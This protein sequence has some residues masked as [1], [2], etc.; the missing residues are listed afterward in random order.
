MEVR[1]AHEILS[2]TLEMNASKLPKET[3][4]NEVVQIDL[5]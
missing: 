3:I 5:I 1:A 4:W 2:V